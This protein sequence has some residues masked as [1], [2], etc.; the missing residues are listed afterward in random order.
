LLPTTDTAVGVNLANITAARKL[1]HAEHLAV[2][3][4]RA[5]NKRVKY[6]RTIALI[7]VERKWLDVE[8][9]RLG[10]EAQ[11]LRVREREL[12]LEALRAQHGAIVLP[13]ASLSLQGTLLES[14]NG[15]L[16][17]PSAPSEHN[18]SRYLVSL[19]SNSKYIVTTISRTKD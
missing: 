2:I 1:K 12:D 16:N 15:T 13:L 3:A 18:L 5:E 7:N 14:T 6:D 10:V 9:A 17:S 19:R 8:R 11:R 4:E